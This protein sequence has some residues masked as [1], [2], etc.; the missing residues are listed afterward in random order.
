MRVLHMVLHVFCVELELE[1][2]L[3][4]E[5]AGLRT[6]PGDDKESLIRFDPFSGY[7]RSKLEEEVE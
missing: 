4:Q 5:G 2:E 3:E 7:S 1:L 6:G